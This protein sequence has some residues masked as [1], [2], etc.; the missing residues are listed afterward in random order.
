M[1]TGQDATQKLRA[2]IQ[3]TQLQFC[4]WCQLWGAPCH[5]INRQRL[6]AQATLHV[7]YTSCSGSSLDGSDTASA[8][9]TKGGLALLLA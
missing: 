3:K 5:E 6:K 4:F 2:A 8:E 9:G 7:C 1:L